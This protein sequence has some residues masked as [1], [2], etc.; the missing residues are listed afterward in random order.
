LAIEKA[1]QEA[2]ISFPQTDVHLHWSENH[3]LEVGKAAA[4]AKEHPKGN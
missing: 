3:L 2:G 4:L 1:F